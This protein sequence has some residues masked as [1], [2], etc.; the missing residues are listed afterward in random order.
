MHTAG[1]RVRRCDATEHAL[2]H[3]AFERVSVDAPWIEVDTTT[4]G[5]EPALG[6]IVAFVNGQG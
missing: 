4:D 5:Y 3:N 2:G 6:E 1:G